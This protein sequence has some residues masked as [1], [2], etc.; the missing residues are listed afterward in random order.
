[1]ET[2]DIFDVLR[3]HALLIVLLCVVTTLAGH[4]VSFISPLVPE[5]YEASAVVLVR[6]HEQ[7]KI[8]PNSSGKEFSDYP[9]AQTPDGHAVRFGELRVLDGDAAQGQRRTY[10]NHSRS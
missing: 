4:G 10:A 7:I 2:I 3:R 6:P 1:M 8:E 9:V 5:K